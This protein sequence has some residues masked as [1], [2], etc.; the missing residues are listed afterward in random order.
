MTV[1]GA[2]PG[3]CVRDAQ[4]TFVRHVVGPSPVQPP[5]PSLDTPLTRLLEVDFVCGLPGVH[6][7]VLT[8][9]QDD[10]FGAVYFYTIGGHTPAV[11]SVDHEGREVASVRTVTCISP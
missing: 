3:L 10:L 5:W 9:I 4:P 6:T 2:L 7:L 8:A 1:N 11:A